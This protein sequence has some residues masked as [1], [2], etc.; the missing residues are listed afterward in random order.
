MKRCL[1]ML[2]HGKCIRGGTNITIKNNPL[3]PITIISLAS[4]L[5]IAEPV[6]PYAPMVGKNF[7]RDVFFGDTHLHT[8]LSPDAAAGGNRLFGHDEAYKLAMGKEVTAHNGRRV[9]LNRPLDFLVAADHA[10]YMGLFPALD[11]KN[12]QLLATDIGQRWYQMLQDGPEAA[13]RKSTR[14]NSSH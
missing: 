1:G 13:D 6:D 3:I 10:E 7:P 5:S 14:L 4:M 8:N 11:A 2:G 12:S 9:R